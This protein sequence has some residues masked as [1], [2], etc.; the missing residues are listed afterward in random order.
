[1]IRVDYMTPGIM[2]SVEPILGLRNIQIIISSVKIDPSTFRPFAYSGN[3]EWDI[4]TSVYTSESEASYSLE[5]NLQ[6]CRFEVTYYIL[7]P[8]ENWTAS[9]KIRSIYDLP[10][11]QLIVALQGN[12][13]AS[14]KLTPHSTSF[15]A[16]QREGWIDEWQAHEAISG[17]IIWEFTFPDDIDNYF[18]LGQSFDKIPD[19]EQ[20]TIHSQNPTPPLNQ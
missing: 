18:E 1:I 16:N 5:Y 17:E 6:E 4:S 7:A 11:C 2:E 15:K 8:V 3:E 19:S 12:D 14:L 20:D 9:G 13:E 10:N